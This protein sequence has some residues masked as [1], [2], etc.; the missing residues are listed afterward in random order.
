MT[1]DANKQA[2]EFFIKRAQISSETAD[3]HCADNEFQKGLDLYKHAYTPWEWHDELRDYAESLGL[4]FFST[5]F[6]F[7]A[8]DLAMES[9][10]RFS[11]RYHPFYCRIFYFSTFIL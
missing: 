11:A 6:D 3:R 2:V 5:P 4:V 10:L 9:I 8:I 7:T 1:P